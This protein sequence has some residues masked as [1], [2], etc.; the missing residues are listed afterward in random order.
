MHDRL[1]EAGAGVWDVWASFSQS[2]SPKV[3]PST[4]PPP[5]GQTSLFLCLRNTNVSW[6]RGAQRPSPHPGSTSRHHC[7]PS[8]PA[9]TDPSPPAVCLGSQPPACPRAVPPSRPLPPVPGR[10]LQLCPL[11][12]EQVDSDAQS[13]KPW[14]GMKFVFASLSPFPPSALSP[15]P[16][17]SLPPPSFPSSHTPLFISPLSCICS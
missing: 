9:C 15:A 5:P 14:V 10:Q 7:A 4:A 2:P 13:H 1:A 11:L 6:P 17:Y 12:S 8:A 16:L 3:M